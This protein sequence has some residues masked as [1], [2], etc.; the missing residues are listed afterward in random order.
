M[1]APPCH[2]PVS[3]ALYGLPTHLF[4]VDESSL[5]PSAQKAPPSTKFTICAAL[6]KYP[7]HRQEMSTVIVSN[8]LLSLWSGPQVWIHC[9]LF[10][11]YMTNACWSKRR[12]KY[13]EPNGYVTMSRLILLWR[14]N[15]LWPLKNSG[16]YGSTT[17]MGGRINHHSACIKPHCRWCNARHYTEKLH[18]SPYP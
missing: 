12:W 11:L 18:Y 5:W 8:C 16:S 6:T 3:A 1:P 17:L 2:F 7:R 10:T 15:V 14:S 4:Q 13:V 9:L